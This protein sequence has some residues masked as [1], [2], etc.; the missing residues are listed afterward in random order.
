MYPPEL[1]FQTGERVYS[2]PWSV[3]CFQP[4]RTRYRCSCSIRLGTMH[5]CLHTDV[6]VLQ[7]SLGHKDAKGNLEEHCIL[8]SAQHERCALL[9]SL[10]VCELPVL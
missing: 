5:R 9:G 10:H 4:I 6:L 2:R 7:P 1:W 8:V 3:A